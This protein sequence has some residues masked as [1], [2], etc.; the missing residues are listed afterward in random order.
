MTRR[1]RWTRRRRWRREVDFNGRTVAYA[2]DAAGRLIRRTNGAGEATAYVRDACGRVAERRSSDAITTFTYDSAGQL[3]AAVTPETTLTLARDAVGRVVAEE[4]NGRAVHT[5]Y[6]ILGR[7]M[8]RRTPSGALSRWDWDANNRPTRVQLADNTLSF[9]YGPSGHE[10]ERRLGDTAVLSQAW[11]AGHRLTE[12]TVLRREASDATGS[13]EALL[14][15]SYT[16][17]QD[18]GLTAIEDETYGIRRFSRDRLGRVEAV[19][20][21]G[22][23]E[24]YAYDAA[25]NIS[26]ADAPEGPQ[27]ERVHDGTLIRRT[28]HITYVHDAQGR[29]VRQT[30]KLLS[31]GT[32]EWTYAWDAE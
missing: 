12:Q 23:S 22:W 5:T 13:D 24:R 21:T 14:H 17:G 3:I 32:R 29:L 16:Y 7:R 18:G 26:R 15:R 27:G 19:S 20:A 6:D 30:R 9:A 2:Y 25:G 1:A 4:C 8:E 10:I 11:D 28:G 31:G